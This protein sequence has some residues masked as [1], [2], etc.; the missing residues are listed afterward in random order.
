MTRVLRCFKVAEET[1]EVAAAIIGATGQNPRKGQT[2]TWDDVQSELCDVILSGMVALASI[3]P[4]AEAVFARHVMAILVRA[5]R[6]GA[7]IEP[8]GGQR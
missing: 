5:S 4:D 8:D 6:S 2:H 3:S 1:G 7:E